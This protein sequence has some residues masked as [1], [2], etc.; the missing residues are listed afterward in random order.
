M[1]SAGVVVAKW[2]EGGKYYNILDNTCVE[3]GLCD[4][5]EIESIKI[6]NQSFYRK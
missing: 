2:I 5:Y 4:N 3:D 1:L 6:T